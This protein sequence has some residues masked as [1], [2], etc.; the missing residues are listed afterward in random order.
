MVAEA[1]ADNAMNADATEVQALVTTTAEA[2][3]ALTLAQ[4][5]VAS[6][7]RAESIIVAEA[8]A[9]DAM[10]AD[11]TEV[12]ALVIATAEASSVSTL[13]KSAA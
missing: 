13:V 3:T 1:I 5:A 7:C 9:E 10:N 6:P 12:E 4:A 11:A 2:N 8:L